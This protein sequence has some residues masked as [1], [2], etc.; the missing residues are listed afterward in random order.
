MK[1]ELS[2]I[3]F[4]SIGEPELG[5]ISVADVKKNIPFEI[6]RT[7]WSY[8]T[9][10]H[11][12]RGKHAHR[13]LIQVLVAVAGII[14]VRTEDRNGNKSEFQLDSPHKGLYI[15]ARFWHTMEFSHNAVLLSLASQSYSEQ[16]YIRNYEDFKMGND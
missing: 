1:N 5:Y 10:H 7:F 16:D 15:P 9:P 11:V 2:I 6:K 4:P 12:I 3:E 14:T 13:Q 8:Y